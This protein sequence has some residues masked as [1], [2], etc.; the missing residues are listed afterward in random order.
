MWHE[1]LGVAAVQSNVTRGIS[2]VEQLSFF[3]PALYNHK[4][5][6]TSEIIGGIFY[7]FSSSCFSCLRFR[8]GDPRLHKGWH[9]KMA[10]AGGGLHHSYRTGPEVEEGTRMPFCGKSEA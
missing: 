4:H 3:T 9:R 7:R 10:W 6:R 1:V 2:A 5:V 8:P